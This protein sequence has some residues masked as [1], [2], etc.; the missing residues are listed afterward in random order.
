MKKII[1]AFLI[2]ASNIV[3]AQNTIA[4]LKYEEA[5]EL[6]STGEFYE[7]LNK[8]EEVETLLGSSNPKILYLQILSLSKIIE[9]VPFKDYDR[10]EKTR[11]IIVKYLKEYE[12][13][14]DNEDKYRDIY[15]ISELL[16]KYP[17]TKETFNVWARPQL[18][19]Y[20]SQYIKDMIDLRDKNKTNYVFEIIPEQYCCIIINKKKFDYDDLFPVFYGMTFEQFQNRSKLII[21]EDGS[22]FYDGK[23]FLEFDNK[24]NAE[25]VC[26]AIELLLGL[27]N[28]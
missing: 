22:I 15:K 19:L 28:K 10:I 24:K 3:C 14:P 13:L 26:K 21:Q 6:Y 11:N 1:I 2:I 16:R 4:K 23:V 18:Q 12:N 20:N 17:D 8:L 7:T 5:E 9:R 25:N 27:K